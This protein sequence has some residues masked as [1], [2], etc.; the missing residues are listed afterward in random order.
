M[1]ETYDATSDFRI[2]KE[3]NFPWKFGFSVGGDLDYEFIEFDEGKVLD[4]AGI[5]WTMA[6]Y[7]SSGTPAIWRNFSGVSKFGVGPGQL[8]LHP[9]PRP[10]GDFA[11]LR[12]VCPTSGLFKISGRFHAG[13]RGSASGRIVLN[14]EFAAP[15]QYFPSTSDGNSVFRLKPLE[16]Q[17]GDTLDL[18]VGN[19]GN[20]S[21]GN[22]PAEVII[23]PSR[24]GIAM[25]GGGSKGDFQVGAVHLLY[26]LGW[27]PNVI[28][29]TSVG[30]VN[31]LKL[32]EGEA[33]GATKQGLQGLTHLWLGLKDY[34]GFFAFQPWLSG[35]SPV[36]ILA[37]QY[38][39][40]FA[41]ANPKSDETAFATDEITRFLL[42]Q[43]AIAVKTR[44][45]AL[46]SN[47]QAE[48]DRAAW[49]SLLAIALPSPVTVIG[50]WSAMSAVV[51]LVLSVVNLSSDALSAGSVFNLSPTR[52]MAVS[53]I[54]PSKI[55]AW[56][57]L[58]NQ[59]RMATVGL[60][61]GALLYVDERGLVTDRKGMPIYKGSAM[62]P[63]C[64]AL[65]L[66]AITVAGRIADLRSGGRVSP[67][68]LEEIKR[69]QNDL[70][71]IT[72]SLAECLARD[73]SSP[74]PLKVNVVDGMIASAA[75][76][77]FFPAISLGGD[78]CVDGGIR[79]VTPAQ[80]SVDRGSNT[81]FIIQAS[82]PDVSK[83]DFN[84]V[85]Q[86]AGIGARSLMEIAINE[87]AQSDVASILNSTL[88]DARLIEP[89]V[90]IHG[91]FTIYPAFIR[92]RIAYG[93]MC[94]ADVL[95]PPEDPATAERMR[96]I[97][98]RISILRYA[99]ARLECWRSGEL[100]PPNMVFVPLSSPA[101]D[102]RQQVG[103]AIARIKAEIGRLVVERREK[104]GR[105][106]PNGVEW[107][108]PDSWHL[109]DEVHPWSAGAVQYDAEIST[110]PIP[111][112]LFAGE[113]RD[114]GIR[115]TNSGSATWLAAENVRLWFRPGFDLPDLPIDRDIPAGGTFNV[116][117]KLAC[118]AMLSADF[119]CQMVRGN[120]RDHFGARSPRTRVVCKPAGEAPRCAE[121]RA[122][123]VSGAAR[124]TELE[125]ELNGDIHHDAG[126]RQ[127]I[128]L[129]RQTMSRLST[130]AAQ[131]GCA[132]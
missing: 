104:G 3:A 128:I 100:I 114:V 118:P 84:E 79:E 11:V 124:I 91:T 110:D 72:E 6:N 23:E 95:E 87:I 1:P 48:V 7:Q 77:A 120:I 60:M 130:E 64:A 18:V 27:R 34:A 76:P 69:L 117:I 30:S 111:E 42:E 29:A 40:D 74:I 132:S 62:T 127:D 36:K 35:D 78:M 13:D 56:A 51:D 70:Q 57:D 68:I 86:I 49:T 14:R 15:L 75:I 25:S 12:F 101:Y 22:T 17:Q 59:L 115:V 107:G 39:F 109:R 24:V 28:S 108:G 92:N 73:P 105:L 126:I 88:I 94:A 55:A 129:V 93:Y 45:T 83:V 47:L 119:E 21:F 41:S 19:N 38:L 102:Y 63:Q 80:A 53:Q 85:S 71:L 90:D 37:R 97:A 16:L 123:L 122:L 125:S 81:T 46:I 50:A 32:S 131:L 52:Q 5:G 65:R 98:D 8:S 44:Q 58:G 89:R 20:F 99:A 26:E 10:N 54:D 66:E 103:A 116:V 67:L 31:G 33:A 61:S 9:G 96:D 112:G 106:P 121:I 2:T 82:K 113:A 43:E 4:D